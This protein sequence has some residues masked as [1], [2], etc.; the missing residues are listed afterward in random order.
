MGST[1]IKGA[2]LQLTVGATD[3][4]ADVTSVTLNNEEA[5]AG[6]T[7]FEDA[8]L[9]GARQFYLEGTAIQSTAAASFWSYLWENTGDT[10][11]YVYAP[12]GNDTPSVTEPHFSG[13]VKVPAKPAVGGEAGVTVEY[14]FDFRMDCQEEPTLITTVA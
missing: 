12:H 5:A 1:R 3:Y 8:S 4:W 2:A 10:V 7:T 14:T 13:T 11:A 9:G 6:V